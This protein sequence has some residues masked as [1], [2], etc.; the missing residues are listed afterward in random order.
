M[1]AIFC[2][3]FHKISLTEFWLCCL[4]HSPSVHWNTRLMDWE[5]MCIN[6]TKHTI[7][8]R[9]EKVK[10][11]IFRP[12]FNNI[13]SSTL[14]CL[15]F[16]VFFNPYFDLRYVYTTTAI[17]EKVWMNT[18]DCVFSFVF[19]SKTKLS[20]VLYCHPYFWR[21]IMYLNISMEHLFLFRIRIVYSV[22]GHFQTMY[23]HPQIGCHFRYIAT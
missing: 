2:P 23:A 3:S 5:D 7:L 14:L 11:D 10:V 15:S 9:L 4:I 6:I 17:F 8:I 16:V 22:D 12:W 21:N 18:L 1:L 19:V 13:I 20:D